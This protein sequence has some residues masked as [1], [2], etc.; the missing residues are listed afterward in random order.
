MEEVKIENI[1]EMFFEF[2]GNCA[3]RVR[4]RYNNLYLFKACKNSKGVLNNTNTMVSEC[5]LLKKINI[6]EVLKPVNLV[7]YNKSE[8]ILFENYD[9]KPL[10][11]HLK[12]VPM[13]IERFLKIALVVCNGLISLQKGQI[14]HG[15]L[16]PYN[17]LINEKNND[18]RFWGIKKDLNMFA[19]DN[20]K[21]C[22]Y[23]CPEKVSKK[24]NMNYSSDYYSLGI[25][26]YEMLSGKTPF[27]NEDVNKII[28]CHLS[29]TPRLLSDIN[30]KVPKM[31][32]KI[33]HKLLNKDLGKRYKSA[34]GI[35][36]DLDECMSKYNK[37]LDI[38]KFDIPIYDVNEEVYLSKKFYGRQKELEELNIY[39]SEKENNKNNIVFLTGDV[40]AGKTTLINKFIQK[41]KDSNITVINIDGKILS[42]ESVI[43]QTLNELV[44]YVIMEESID[45]QK[46]KK[47]IETIIEGYED[48][49]FNFS[50]FLRNIFD[51]KSSVKSYNVNF[52]YNT[53]LEII[54]KLILLLKDN[55]RNLLL[56]VNEIDLEFNNNL[57]II[58]EILSYCELSQAVIVVETINKN[59]KPDYQR[60]II[61][62]LGNEDKYNYYFLNIS[63]L[64]IED[65]QSYLKD[66]FYVS[67]EVAITMSYAIFNKTQGNP[68][69]VEQLVYKSIED[70]QIYFNREKWKWELKDISKKIY[71][72]DI[73]EYIGNIV[74]NMRKEKLEVLYLI[75]KS[76]YGL[77]IDEIREITD[78]DIDFL[79]KIIEYLVYNNFIISQEKLIIN[80]KNYIE[81]IIIYKSS[82]DF[83]QKYVDESMNDEHINI[84]KKIVKVKLKNLSNEIINLDYAEFDS[85]IKLIELC[86]YIAEDEDK[87]KL[88]QIYIYA[89]EQ[90]ML[91]QNYDQAGNLF[92]KADDIY[93][94]KLSEKNY[95]LYFKLKKYRAATLAST[96]NIVE[97]EKILKNLINNTEIRTSVVLYT[98]RINN[99]LN[100]SKYNEAC[101]VSKECLK[102]L[103]MNSIIIK[104]N[105]V[106]YINLHRITETV[107]KYMLD[108][109]LMEFT[110]KSIIAAS[111][112][113]KNY[114]NALL[115]L[116]Y[117]YDNKEKNK[118]FISKKANARFKEEKELQNKKVINEIVDRTLEYKEN[119]SVT[120]YGICKMLPYYCSY[121]KVIRYC[122][123]LNNAINN[124]N[125]YEKDFYNIFI[126]FILFFKGTNLREVKLKII[127]VNSDLNKCKDKQLAEEHLMLSRVIESL[128]NS[129]QE[130][131]V[132]KNNETYLECKKQGHISLIALEYLCKFLFKN[133]DSILTDIIYDEEIINNSLDSLIFQYFF[134]S[135]LCL[136]EIYEES[137]SEIKS[138]I[139]SILGRYSE[140]IRV[141]SQICPKNY[142]DEYLIIK[143]I[144]F[145]LQRNFKDA[146]KLLEQ[147]MIESKKNKDILSEAIANEIAF[148]VCRDN[149]IMNIGKVYL[150]NSINLYEK[151]GALKKSNQLCMSNR[152]ILTGSDLKLSVEMNN[153]IAQIENMELD[154]VIN[155]LQTISKEMDINILLK[156]LMNII[157]ENTKAERAV[158]LSNYNNELKI[159]IEG[160]RNLISLKDESFLQFNDISRNIVFYVTK[161]KEKLI[162]ND[163][164]GDERFIL[165]SYIRKNK[166]KSIACYPMIIQGKCIGVIY[167][168]NNCITDAFKANKIDVLEYI[169]IQSGISISNA[170]MY[171]ELENSNI[172]LESIIEE[173]TMELK[174][175]IENLKLEIKERELA[176]SK[177]VE[178]EKRYKT[179]FYSIPELVYLYDFNEEAV[180][181]SND[182]FKNMIGRIDNIA[183]DEAVRFFTLDNHELNLNEIIINILKGKIIEDIVVKVVKNNK[184][185]MYLNQTY[186]P[187]Y[188]DNQINK[189][190]CLSKDITDSMEIENA[191]KREKEKNDLLVKALEYDKLKTEFFA[192]LSH[193]F[194]TPLN[195][196]LGSIQLL[197]KIPDENFKSDNIKVKNYLSM[198]KQNCYRLLRLVNNLIDI[199]RLEDGYL[200]LKL[201]E[202]DIVSVV[203]NIVMS[204][205]QYANNKNIDVIFDTDVEEK[206]MVFDEEKLERILLNI[207]SNALK[208][209]NEKGNIQVTVKDNEEYVIISIKDDGIGIPEEKLEG[210]FNRFEQVD[211]S[212]SRN[213][214]GSGIGLSLTKMLVELHGGKIRALSEHGRGSEFIMQIPCNLKSEEN[215]FK[216]EEIM[217]AKEDKTVEKISIEF[218]DIYF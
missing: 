12:G 190:I 106:Y 113:D 116:A 99:Y 21:L 92:D 22:Q 196:I 43:I 214:E 64:K 4:D 125:F 103:S 129:N 182:M 96:G 61:K 16:N 97:S 93:K 176:D 44:I 14:I 68:F 138:K 203:E 168:E 87:I 41:I 170:K 20:S 73:K 204:I 36:K 208:F 90:A 189:M 95:D 37:Y 60:S 114:Y 33:I 124:K 155:I 83:L 84:L 107:Q 5:E 139:K 128:T 178:S 185:I 137:S 82:N 130:E 213:H 145:S 134:Y 56:K 10:V 200:K 75:D 31:I 177:L 86:E 131:V 77:T 122:S 91:I 198:M 202:Y 76:I 49:V 78:L 74:H 85:L 47:D 181:D 2:D 161:M 45:F 163:A 184:L 94:E 63:N 156:N 188:E 6:E 19:G 151:W 32:S 212:L 117:K 62:E 9:G 146:L 153:R 17:I 11:E 123:A 48:I 57:E 207:L 1:E 175:S 191:R 67:E 133:Y 53:F 209:T 108:E 135:S 206:L 172:K 165:D 162:I 15:N 195:V 66:T 88:I 46:F 127:N 98:I 81:R 217:A 173:K 141:H 211:K 126:N 55:N 186:I 112:V 140:K 150:I 70:S 25:I 215:K 148:I 132:V 34:Q 54:N 59:L 210:I 8:G 154:S 30:N 166:I 3:A 164:I 160:N 102:Y 144:Y 18:V 147:S 65:I 171:E 111:Y 194:K 187:I 109:V 158:I 51:N 23:I 180:I 157:I 79:K 159:E 100:S 80:D 216:E 183:K 72:Q 58:K 136:Y 201:N 24:N 193:E 167:L 115:Q 26:F 27:N 38:P 169:A 121:T 192:N 40:G 42:K 50:P 120:H 143:A 197:N 69:L 52:S 199:T 174:K 39:F 118:F 7:E 152:S 101:I 29:K 71:N 89:G 35:K 218:S 179:I 119:I 205:V 28:Y 13:G 104:K 110:I 149:E 105:Y 142:M